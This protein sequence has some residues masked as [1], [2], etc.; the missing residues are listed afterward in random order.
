MELYLSEY[1]DV[2]PVIYPVTLEIKSIFYVK[3]PCLKIEL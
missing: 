1:N 2:H 3:E